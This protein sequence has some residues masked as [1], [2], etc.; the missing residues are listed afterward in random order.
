MNEEAANALLKTLEEPVSQTTLILIAE[1]ARGLLATIVSRC[2]RV[3]FGALPPEDLVALLVERH[4]LKGPEAQDLARLCEGSPG[5]ALRFHEEGVLASRETLLRSL[6]SGG[7]LQEPEKW[8]GDREAALRL[9]RALAFWY[10]DLLTLKASGTADGQGAGVRRGGA[11][12]MSTAEILG[13]LGVVAQTSLDIRRHA[14]MRL[15]FE[16]MRAQLCSLSHK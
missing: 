9:L 14:N 15:A 11:P 10:R 3:V 4:G 16:Q 13:S 8:A 1:E 12:H 2:Q 7:S 5:E 6:A